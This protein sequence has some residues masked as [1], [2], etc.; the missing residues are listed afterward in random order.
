MTAGPPTARP[1]TVRL[2]RPATTI[3]QL[4][5]AVLRTLVERLPAGEAAL[6]VDTLPPLLAIAA[7]PDPDTGYGLDGEP[8]ARFGVAELI[9]RVR[10]RTARYDDDDQA[11]RCEIAAT[12]HRIAGYC[13]DGLLYRVQL[14]LPDDIRELFPQPVRLRAAGGG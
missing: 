11:V 4:D 13:P 2:D 1:T 10:R 9:R 12:L 6:L 7:R 8:P 14:P 3:W 5:V